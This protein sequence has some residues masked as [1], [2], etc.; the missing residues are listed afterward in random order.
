[1]GCGA[2]EVA[3]AL[4]SGRR[5]QNSRIESSESEI[6]GRNNAL[7]AHANLDRQQ[8]WAAH[9]QEPAMRVTG[10][11]M[12]YSTIVGE[13]RSVLHIVVDVTEFLRRRWQPENATTL[14]IRSTRCV[15]L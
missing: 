15:A 14:R 8:S 11:S 9:R 6:P 12:F 5:W 10:L 13:V 4:Q 1:M 7:A 3:L 2:G